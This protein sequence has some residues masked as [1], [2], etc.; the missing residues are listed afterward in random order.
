[1]FINSVPSAHQPCANNINPW[2][3][4]LGKQSLGVL[5]FVFLMLGAMC[6]CSGF[7]SEPNRTDGGVEFISHALNLESEFSAAGKLDV[8]NDGQPD[9]VC[10]AYWYEAPHWKRH[11]FREVEQIRGRFDDYSNLVVDVDRDGAQDIVSVNYRSKS[12]YWVR[13]PG[14]GKSKETSDPGSQK[15]QSSE[16]WE[17]IVI[18]HPGTSE[19]GQL[20]DLD[21][22]GKLDILPAGTNFAAW[23]R[24]VIEDGKVTWKKHDLPEQLIGHGI[25]VGDLNG[26]GRTDVIGSKGWAQAPL[27]PREDRWVWHDEF[28]LARDCSIPILCWDV[29]SDGDLDLVWSRAHDVGLYWTEQ[30]ESHAS[31]VSVDK[32]IADHQAIGMIATRKWVTHAI[33]TSWSNI[34]TLMTADLD[35]DGKLEL[36]AGKR[37]L[38][39][40]GKDPGEYDPL[41]IAWYKFDNSFRIWQRNVIGYGGPCGIDLDSFCAD[42]DQDGDIDIVAPSR[43]GLHWLENRRL[44]KGDKSP[45]VDSQQ[46]A[47]ELSSSSNFYSAKPESKRYTYHTD[48]SYFI[49]GQG[50]QQPIKTPFDHAAR[51]QHILRQM[52][53]VMGELPSSNQRVPLDI[54]IQSIEDFESYWRLHLTYASDRSEDRID[55]VPA[56]LLLPK[57]LTKPAPA[58][59]CLHQTNFELG[60]GEPCGMGKNVNLFI[61]HE[62]AQQGFVCIAPDYP[63]FSEYAYSFEENANLY[64]S[65]TMKGIWNHIRAVDVLESLPC[66]NRDAIGAIGHSLG[67]HNSLF[68][69]AFDLRIRNVITSCGFNSFEDYYSGN[70]KGWTSSRY[71]PRIAS[72]YESSPSKMPFDFPEVLAAIAPRGVF[73]NAP[74]GDSNFAVVGVEKCEVAVK[75]IYQTVFNFSDRLK[76]VYPDAGHD[77]PTPV[78]QQAYEWLKERQ[79]K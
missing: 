28:S 49:N 53:Q 72:Q 45:S 78:R 74:R 51:R 3:C 20:A 34:H 33:D 50:N 58:M 30:I 59:L 57:K 47:S 36:V 7:Q 48:L 15:S 21:A 2:I 29:D 67:G 14:V 1:M 11:R 12:L 19:T 56:F 5:A 6:R 61:A 54:Q 38:A 35:G 66:V 71:M 22:D 70:L 76:F 73:V 37:Y 10:G 69:A 43:I 25:G 13:N 27:N 40:D 63:G 46:P 9:I 31:T 39:H 62:L 55:R 77:F 79:S 60:K 75:P 24:F 17:T 18:D 68:V 32:L 65:G 41:S 23:Y 16:L 64:A 8:N 4:F 44:N 26:D 42:M 52:Q